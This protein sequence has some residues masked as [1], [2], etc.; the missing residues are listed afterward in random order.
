MKA[1]LDKILRS[2]VI[3]SL[4]GLIDHGYGEMTI[5]VSTMGD[6]RVNA[7]VKSSKSHRFVFEKENEDE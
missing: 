2:E 1:K 4:Q 6:H 5:E 7:I 3:D